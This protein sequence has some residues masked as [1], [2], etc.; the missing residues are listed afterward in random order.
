MRV[1]VWLRRVQLARVWSDRNRDAFWVPDNIDD[2]ELREII[3]A[4]QLYFHSLTA[5]PA[6]LYTLLTTLAGNVL[7]DLIEGDIN[8]KSI[9]VAFGPAEVAAARNIQR[10]VRGHLRRVHLKRN[11]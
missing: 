4:G 11:K 6:G 8:R 7:E 3:V 10:V 5:S 2:E 9:I 1:C